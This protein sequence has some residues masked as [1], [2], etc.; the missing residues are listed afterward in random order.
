MATIIIIL[1]VLWAVY[2]TGKDINSIKWD[3]KR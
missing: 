2:S 1:V 3:G